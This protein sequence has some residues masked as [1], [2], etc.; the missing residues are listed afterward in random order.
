MNSPDTYSGV[1]LKRSAWHF[2]GGK[3]ASALLTFLILLWVVRLLT[4]AEY[5]VYVTLV[6]GMELAMIIATLGLPWMA[7][8][9]LPEFRLHAPGAQFRRLVLNLLGWQA[10]ALAGLAGALALGLGVLMDWADLTPYHAVAQVYLLILLAEGIG[11]AVRESLLGPLLLQGFAQIS[12]VVR[13]LVFMAL[14]A[15]ASQT[16][17]VSLMDVVQAELMASVA[18]VLLAL[19]GLAHHLSKAIVFPGKSGWQAPRLARMWRTASQMY[20]A[21]LLSTLYSPQIYLLISQRYLGTESTAVF[22]FLRTLYE[23]ISRY[24][25]ATLMFSL[26]RP[27]LVASY[28]GAGGVVDLSR[29]ANLA[30]K[31]S[32]FVLMPVV[33]FVSVTGQDL[34]SL[35]S[36]A[37]FP[38]SGL[39]F[40]GFMLALIPYSQRQI[41]ETVAVAS[42]HGHLCIRAAASG[43]FMLPLMVGLLMAGLELWAPVVSLGIGY[44]V[45][46]S[47]ILAGLVRHA[48]YRPDHRGLYKLLAAALAGYLAAAWLPAMRS[49]SAHLIIVAMLVMV[50]YLLVAW[51]IKPFSE[52]ERARLNR[53]FNR[54]L[55]I[56]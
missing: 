3:A 10:A 23:Q 25:P 39:L 45:F 16:A 34:V 28:V 17:S 6:A 2:L 9:Y 31:L 52:E 53:L 4:V 1:A 7:A 38:E 36:G 20:F 55:F 42:G 13:N 24:L 49:D 14:L 11:R 46:N 8:R 29:N 5:G 32:L 19:G 40:L 54:K 56:W 30:G 41:L 12:L 27:K 33:A 18:G 35:L 44:V 22:G 51:S 43:L 15:V 37:K 48:D 21:H 26:V 47:V 50:A